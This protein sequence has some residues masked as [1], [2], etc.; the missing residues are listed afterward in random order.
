MLP[1]VLWRCWLGGRKG[2]QPVKTEWWGA[3]VVICLERG[4]DWHMAQLMPLPLTVSC[5]S[6]IRIGFTFLVRAHL[7]S[8]GKRAVKWL[9]VCDCVWCLQG[10]VG[11]IDVMSRRVGRLQAM[12]WC[13]ESSVRPDIGREQ[14]A[15]LSD[16]ASQLD[17]MR[18]TC[19]DR[20]LLSDRNA[21]SSHRPVSVSWLL[22]DSACI[23]NFSVLIHTFVLVTCICCRTVCWHALSVNC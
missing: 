4:A 6:K 1:S 10:L 2:I 16:V 15:Q 3:G 12:A 23:V 13:L 19:C 20:M 8:P 14:V 17:A 5:F 11:D 18:H 7:G 21:A 9:C 22:T